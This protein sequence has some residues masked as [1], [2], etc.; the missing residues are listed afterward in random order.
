VKGIIGDRQQSSALALGALDL[1]T[2]RLAH[3]VNGRCGT[4]RFKDGHENAK[5]SSAG[6]CAAVAAPCGAVGR[7]DHGL[8]P[9]SERRFAVV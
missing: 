9:L 7:L 4:D 1:A 3:V 8:N 6:A 2:E 5:V